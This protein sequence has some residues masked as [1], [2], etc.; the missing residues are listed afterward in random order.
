M[1]VEFPRMAD[2]LAP[3]EI[4]IAKIRHHQITPMDA[5][6]ASLRGIPTREEKVAVLSVN[7]VTMMSDTYHERSTNREFVRQARGD[8]LI[9]GLG[10]GMILHPILADSN[11]ATVT[12]VEKHQDVIDLVRP[13]LPATSKLDLIAADIFEWKPPRG[14]SWDVIYFDIWADLST[15]ELDEMG[16][17]HRKFGRRLRPGGWMNSWCRDQL[18]ARRRRERRSMA[19]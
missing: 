13:T 16:R 1:V 12:I 6:M 14:R 7:G 17:L 4:G 9:A 2:I 11:V 3:A 19:W 18:L 8:V 10:L 15:D 5:A